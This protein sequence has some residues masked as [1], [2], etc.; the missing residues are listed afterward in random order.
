MILEGIKDK[1]NKSV[2]K[3]IKKANEEKERHLMKHPKEI[4]KEYIKKTGTLKN[5][6][7]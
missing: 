6:E 2:V 3:N 4:V 5:I 7:S 1:N